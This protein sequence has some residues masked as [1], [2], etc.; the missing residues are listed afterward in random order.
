MSDEAKRYTDE[1]LEAVRKIGLGHTSTR[2]LATVDALKRELAEA[3]AHT[4]KLVE[5]FDESTHCCDNCQ[6]HAVLCWFD[7]AD[8][9]SVRE[10]R[11]K[12]REDLSAA[13]TRALE[14]EA[15]DVRSQL[16]I[17]LW[18][19]RT[20]SALDLSGQSMVELTAARTK[21]AEAER[22]RDEAK[23]ELSNVGHELEA[24]CM[25][26]DACMNGAAEREAELRELKA[27]DRPWPLVDV[28]NKLADAA[29]TLLRKHDYD[30]HGWEEVGRCRDEARIIAAVIIA[31]PPSPDASQR[32]ACVCGHAKSDHARRDGVLACTVAGCACGPG[33]IHEGFVSADGTMLPDEKPSAAPI[34]DA[35]HGYSTDS[36]EPCAHVRGHAKP[37]CTH[38]ASI[39]KGSET[40]PVHPDDLPDDGQDRV[41][42]RKWADAKAGPPVRV[43][44]FWYVEEFADMFCVSRMAPDGEK[45]FSYVL[46]SAA[47]EPARLLA[48]LERYGALDCTAIRVADPCGTC[49]RCRSRAYL[50][51]S[52]NR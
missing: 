50:A 28:L 44:L 6:T 34:A 30:G 42:G 5:M 26:W 38:C 11:D 3:K 41:A 35:S 47:S 4:L 21:L 46:E 24:V 7:P 16:T 23:Q 15:K 33:C 2:I 31:A 40:T 37:G 12:L 1:E 25:N 43:T 51:R 19:G 9:K 29:D 22:E 14:A 18:K 48:E 27:S 45:R 8:R 10:A 20:E 39:A 13:L 32:L 17:G 52:V 49:A 36:G